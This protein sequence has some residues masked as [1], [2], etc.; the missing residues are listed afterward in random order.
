[1]SLIVMKVPLFTYLRVRSVA[2]SMLEKKTV[3]IFRS[4]W[5][6]YKS[7]DRKD[8]VGDPCMQE[9]IFE[10][11]NSEGHTGFLGNV[12]VTFIDKTDSQNPEKGENYWIHTLKT[13]VLWGLN[14]L[15]SV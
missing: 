7:N 3:D 8:L 15:N 1:M 13:M 11:L 14:I 9:Y 6:N 10:H 12:S 5:S 4:R 2:S